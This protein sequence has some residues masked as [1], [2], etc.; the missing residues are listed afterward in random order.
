MDNGLHST[1]DQ[2]PTEEPS[3]ADFFREPES[4]SPDSSAVELIPTFD[5]L[6][7][8]DDI[9]R[10]IY[11]YGYEEPSP[12]Q[13]RAIKPIIGGRDLIAQ[14]QSGTGKT[15]TFSIGVLERLDMDLRKVQAVILSPTR[16]LAAQTVQV[17]E[18]L[19][20]H[21][22]AVVHGCIGGADRP[23]SRDV[24]LLQQGGVKVVVGTP[25]RIL[26]IFKR[27][28]VDP[29]TIKLLVIDEADEMLAFNFRDQIREILVGLPATT[30]ICM[31]SATLSEDALDLAQHFMSE[32]LHILLKKEKLTLDGIK[33]FYVAVD[34]PRGGD[35]CKLEVL[36][37]LYAVM[38]I[39]QCIIFCNSKRKCEY[40]YEQMTAQDFTC[41]RLHG[42]MSSEERH[43]I[44]REFRTGSSRLLISTDLVARGIDVQT[45]SLV[46]NYELPLVRA[47]YLHRIG[48]SGRCGRKGMAISLITPR[49]VD[50]MRDIEG[51]YHT[52]VRALPSNPAD[53]VTCY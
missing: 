21:L 11:A 23:V 1:K 49:D 31:F 45:V 34:Q 19:G 44:M 51:Y 9:L 20:T 15:A 40:L 8:K 10:S 6:G 52:E 39:S 18:A 46:I 25:G 38:S 2:K 42:D 48:R 12:I 17:V 28:A 26:D 22:G 16:E 7:V 13:Q 4:N 32:P 14:A 53:L 47:N 27:R 3:G 37:D 5:Q 33:Q 30:Q 43:A 41:S 50:S 29:A 24:R 36:F 35:D